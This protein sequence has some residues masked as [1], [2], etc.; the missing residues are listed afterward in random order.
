MSTSKYCPPVMD[1]Q[2]GTE[3]LHSP[4][5]TELI[6]GEAGPRQAG[7]TTLTLEL[8]VQPQFCTWAE[9]CHILF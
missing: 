3:R 4:K 7:S 8:R 2:T 6:S 1:E 5:V 9:G